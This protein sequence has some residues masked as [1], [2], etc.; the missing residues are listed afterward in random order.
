MSKRKSTGFLL[1]FFF[2]AAWLF[3]SQQLFAQP[4]QT[5][6]MEGQASVI[7]YLR[8]GDPSKKVGVFH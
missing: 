8:L 3:M 1:G 4:H 6:E 7:R 5:V 2:I